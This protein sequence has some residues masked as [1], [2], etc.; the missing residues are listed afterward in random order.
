MPYEIAFAKTLEVLD[1]D[2]Y[3]DPCCWGGDLVV[4]RLLPRIV[5]EYQRVRTEQEDW[6][7]FIWFRRGSVR[8]AVDV[9]CDDPATGAF[10]VHLTSRV[11]HLL[12]LDRVVDVPEL[13][14]LN[15]FVVA[16]LESWT[17]E[18]CAVTRLDADH[19]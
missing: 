15:Q 9:F 12:F 16:E 2:Q 10:R 6:G 8:L 14:E 17:G 4:A 1:E 3:I 19:R 13:D 11:K 18:P 5:D 7:W